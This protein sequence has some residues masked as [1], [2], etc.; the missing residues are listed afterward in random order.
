MIDTK[1]KN[2]LDRGSGVQGFWFDWVFAKIL[3]REAKGLIVSGV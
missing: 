3:L 1:F 2:L